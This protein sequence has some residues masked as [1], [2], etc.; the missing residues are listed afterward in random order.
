[1]SNF[2]SISGYISSKKGLR[3]KISAINELIDA[4][5]LRT[6]EAIDDIGASVDEYSMD[7][8]QMKVRTKFRNIDDVTMGINALEK[9]KQR[10]V[11]Q[12]NGRVIALKDIRGIRRCR[13]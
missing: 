6:T 9:I 8:G 12:L 4:M 13:F 11:N 1:V 10:Y 3:E 7:D 5:I 2:Y